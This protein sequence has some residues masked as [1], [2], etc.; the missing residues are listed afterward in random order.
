M[1]IAQ[2]APLV[3]RVPPK[4]YGGTER[5]VYALTEELIKRGHEVT[6]FASGDSETSAKLH[7]VYPRSLRE[8]R[9]IN[10]YG[11]NAWTMLNIGAAYSLYEQ[12]DIIHDHHGY[13][14]LPTANICPT[15]SVITLHGP[16]EEHDK[17]M[18][19]DL[20][21]PHFVTIS[22]Y[23][24]VTMPDLGADTVYN[25]LS[26]E[27]YP[28]YEED[29]GYLLFVGRLSPQKGVHHA[30]NV[31]KKLQ[32]PLIIAAKLEDFDIPYFEENIKPHLGSDIKWLGEVNEEERNTLM[33]RALCFVH[34]TNWPEPFGLTI[35]E[36]MACG[37][38]VV[39]FN[40]GSIPEVII[41]GQTGRV[42][43]T[44]EEMVEAVSHIKRIDR[45]NCRN[46]ALKNFNAAKMTDG[47]EAIYQ[48]IAQ[49]NQGYLAKPEDELLAL[50]A[51]KKVR[52]RI[53]QSVKSQPKKS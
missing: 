38:P 23:Q 33:S 49:D 22:K 40:M 52:E 35:I 48:R 28:F 47:Y 27:H 1:R 31:A 53:K 9:V 13:A 45:K 6:L 32:L 4:K 21:N 19:K 5:V 2:I 14:S 50:R 46:Y 37:T 51:L 12:F 34:P 26:M 25:G 15:P 18:L 7:A 29:E 16:I 11:F 41:D 20:N 43:Y 44:E 24:G 17:Q 10:L 39:A 30:I 3:E 8:E 36:S 42:V